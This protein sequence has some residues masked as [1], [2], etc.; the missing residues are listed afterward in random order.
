M[1]NINLESIVAKD[2]YLVDEKTGRK[3]VFYECDPIKNTECSKG[4]CRCE[5]SEDEGGFGFCSKTVNPEFRKEGGKAWHAI[6][7]TPEEGEPYWGREYIE[8]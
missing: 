8:E 6:L 7:K 1:S 4:M 2:G 5:T 3:V